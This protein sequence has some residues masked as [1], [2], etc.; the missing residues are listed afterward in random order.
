MVAVGV[1]RDSKQTIAKDTQL[2]DAD[3]A[4]A[5]VD[6][7]ERQGVR[8]RAQDAGISQ[9]VIVS[10]RVIGK[11]TF[12]IVL[13]NRGMTSELFNSVGLNWKLG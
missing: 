2:G 10:E 5:S 11:T 9:L 12:D 3:N 1:E 13:E 4:D 6:Q 8:L 7:S